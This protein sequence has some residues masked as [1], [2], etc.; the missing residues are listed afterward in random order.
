MANAI[1][2]GTQ[3]IGGVDTHQDLPPLPSWT[4]MER[5]SAPNRSPPPGPATGRC[6]A[7]SGLTGSCFA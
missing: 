2:E 6:F 1:A 4:S 5:Y 3:I 7:G